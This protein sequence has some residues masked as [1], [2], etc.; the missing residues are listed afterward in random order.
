MHCSSIPKIIHDMQTFTYLFVAPAA[1]YVPMSPAER[2]R[3]VAPAVPYVTVV[4]PDPTYVTV[5]PAAPMSPAAPS[6]P[7]A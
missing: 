6:R 1:P 5:T 4:A 3:P 7:V 2:S